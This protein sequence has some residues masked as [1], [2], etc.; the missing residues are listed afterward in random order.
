[1][2]GR[3]KSR[4]VTGVRLTSLPS[5]PTPPRNGPSG[6]PPASG[7]GGQLLSLLGVGGPSQ[8]LSLFRGGEWGDPVAVASIPP[9]CQRPC[10]L[11]DPQ[12]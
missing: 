12:E 10:F 11:P 7:G 1:M 4:E 5:P 3:P 8:L 9:S 2:G 6:T